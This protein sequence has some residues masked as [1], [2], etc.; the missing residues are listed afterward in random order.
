MAK[1]KADFLQAYYDTNGIDFRTRMV[2]QVDKF[3]SLAAYIPGI[4]NWIISNATTGKYVKKILGFSDKRKLPTIAKQPLREW[5]IKKDK[6]LYNSEAKGD[7]YFFFDEFTNFND[8]EIGKKA[9]LLVEKLG[10][11]VLMIKHEFS[12]RALISKGMLREAKKIANKN[13]QLFSSRLRDNIALVAVEPSTILTFRDEY[14]DLVDEDLLDDAKRIAPHTMILEEFLW[15]EFEKGN[16]TAS[17]FYET[18]Q[19]VLVH[20][21]CQQKAWKLQ[22]YTEKVLTIPGGNTVKTIASGCC[23]M[24][25]SFGYEKEHYD[26][27]MKIGELVLFPAVRDKDKRTTIVAPGASCRHQIKDGTNERALHPVEVLYDALIK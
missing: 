22:H 14:I 6:P 3:T 21:H 5:F 13:V 16:I 12:G 7:V 25:G 27:S 19:D 23:G 18:Q 17:Q 11:N 4:Y 24:A 26:I 1:L 10:Y 2:G 15:K 9:I 8:V 20:A